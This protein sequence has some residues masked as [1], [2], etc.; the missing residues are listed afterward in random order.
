MSGSIDFFWADLPAY[1][2]NFGDVLWEDI[3]KN[4]GYRPET[5]ALKN[6]RYVVPKK[7]FQFWYSLIKKK[8]PYVSWKNISYKSTYNLALIVFRKYYFTNPRYNSDRTL[9][10]FN[11]R[12]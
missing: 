4:L 11:L 7:R 1:N 10:F 2:E 6:P 8:N 12:F 9:T 5:Y 3:R